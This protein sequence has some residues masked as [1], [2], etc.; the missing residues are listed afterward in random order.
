M[1]ELTRSNLQNGDKKQR[2]EQHVEG[3]IICTKGGEIYN[4][5]HNIQYIQF[6]FTGTKFSLT[7]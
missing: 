4:S 7:G 5:E 3:A 1:S 2:A 6:P